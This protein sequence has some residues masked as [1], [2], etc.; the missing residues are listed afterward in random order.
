MMK[1]SI[2]WLGGLV[3]GSNMIVVSVYLYHLF[4]CMH[5]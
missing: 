2:S 1:L 3:A 4:T 5:I